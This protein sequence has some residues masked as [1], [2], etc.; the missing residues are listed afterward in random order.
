MNSGWVLIMWMSL[1]LSFTDDSTVKEESKIES[2]YYDNEEAC[3][4]SGEDWK[5][6]KFISNA[7]RTARHSATI[8]DQ[9]YETWC[10]LED[11]EL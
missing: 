6:N 3:N 9:N 4:Q 1:S 11:A 10:E 5:R 8:V 7:M 2:R